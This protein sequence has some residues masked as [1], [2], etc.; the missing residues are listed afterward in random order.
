MLRFFLFSLVWEKFNLNFLILQQKITP[1]KKKI[2]FLFHKKKIIH[3]GGESNSGSSKKIKNTLY[4]IVF[5]K[6]RI[7]IRQNRCAL[8][9]FWDRN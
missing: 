9:R 8:V 2:S 7:K 1:Q 5:F 6:C 3:R 4:P